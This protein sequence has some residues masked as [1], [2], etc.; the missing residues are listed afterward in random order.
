[1]SSTRNEIW[2]A[3]ADEHDMRER[4]LQRGH[5]PQELAGQDEEWLYHRL[6]KE[7]AY[8]RD[9]GREGNRGP[10]WEWE[11]RKWRLK[12]EQEM[13]KAAGEKETGPAPKKEG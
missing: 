10:E 11:Q 1:M 6:E 5:S 8:D 9:E 13:K 2:L 3:E 7:F 4:L 12:H